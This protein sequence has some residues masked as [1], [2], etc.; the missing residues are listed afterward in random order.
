MRNPPDQT[1][2]FD[3][4]FVLRPLMFL[5]IWAF[6]VFGYYH[7]AQ[8][9]GDLYHFGFWRMIPL[10]PL[11]ILLLIFYSFLH[12]GANILNQITDYETDKITPAVW[13][14]AS[15]RFPKNQAWWEMIILDAISISWAALFSYEIL[16]VFLFILILGTAYSTPPVKFSSRPFL[17]FLS[18][19]MG[20]GFASF[21][22]GWLAGGGSL[23]LSLLWVSLPY[24][25]LMMSVGALNPEIP[26]IEDD[27]ASGK[28][29]TAVKF[30]RKL[31]IRFSSG[32]L[33]LSIIISLIQNNLFTLST[34]LVALLFFIIALIR[35]R[36]SDY[37]RT[38]H[39]PG[40]FMV[41]IAGLLF[42]PLLVAFVIIYFASRAYYPWRFGVDYPKV[43]K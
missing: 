31:V 5:P 42:V 28:I 32:I 21:A 17:G 8:M 35:D 43:G 12:G 34:G 40:P 11:F 36:R 3:F 7:S 2:I 27:T 24:V 37:L 22:V 30:G 15:G 9:Q 14:I 18:N 19:T 39:L 26:D 6:C 23:N 29:T 38:Y 10:D 16:M 20:P 41:L 4:F 13:L 33:L 25:L 1:A